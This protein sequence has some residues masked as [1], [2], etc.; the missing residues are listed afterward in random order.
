MLPVVIYEADD[1]ARAEILSLLSDYGKAHDRR[2][3]VLGN[4]GSLE[5]ASACLKSE[6][7]SCC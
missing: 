3:Y 5:E 7:A 2:F 1:G 6:G 4:T